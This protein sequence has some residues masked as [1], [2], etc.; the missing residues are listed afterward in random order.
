MQ[1]SPTS[2]DPNVRQDSYDV[3]LANSDGRQY[4][5]EEHYENHCT[6]SFAYGGCDSSGGVRQVNCVVSFS[7]F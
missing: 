1:S 5:Q 6:E 2:L 7:S 3:K 4:V